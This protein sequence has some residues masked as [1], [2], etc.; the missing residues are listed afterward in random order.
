[1][2]T[3]QAIML[4]I[5]SSKQVHGYM[6]LTNSSWQY[7]NRAKPTLKTILTPCKDKNA[8]NTCHLLKQK[9]VLPRESIANLKKKN[10]PNSKSQM[11]W[12]GVWKYCYEPL[13]CIHARI[14]H[15]LRKMLSQ[16]WQMLSYQLFKLK[17]VLLYQRQ[18]CLH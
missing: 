5:Y 7:F 3:K 10:I 9:L 18:S 16:L 12:K 11:E 17:E 15:F 8:V 2:R 4:T 14:Y 13:A 1:M 6:I